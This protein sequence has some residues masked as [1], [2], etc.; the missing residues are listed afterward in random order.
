MAVSESTNN[1]VSQIMVALQQLQLENE[2]LQD[3]LREPEA[4]TLMNPNAIEPNLARSLATPPNPY[5]LEP[6]V[7]HLKI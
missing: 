4:S 1:L 3:S 7:W 2:I 6:K 5:I